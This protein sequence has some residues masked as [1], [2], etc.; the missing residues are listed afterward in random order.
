MELLDSALEYGGDGIYA[1][2]LNIIQPVPEPAT[3]ALTALG[4]MILFLE[5]QLLQTV[6]SKGFLRTKKKGRETLP[7]FSN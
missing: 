5:K 4:G 2:T 3:W 7:A 6:V 1:G